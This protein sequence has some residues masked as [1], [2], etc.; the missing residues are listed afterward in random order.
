M[1][2]VAKAIFAGPGRL[3][4]V[5]FLVF[6]LVGVTLAKPKLGPPSIK[7]RTN[8]SNVVIAELDSVSRDHMLTF[9][10]RENLHNEQDESIVIRSDELTSSRL[11][12]GQTYVMAFVKWSVQS[13]PRVVKPRRDGAVIIYLPGAEPA[14]FQ[15]NDEMIELF[16]IDLEESLQSPDE[17]LPV[18]LRGMSEADPQLQ[19][20][21]ATELVTRPRLY[22]QLSRKEKRTVTG[23]I[24]DPAYSPSARDL[25][26]RTPAFTETLMRQN[27]KLDIA[28]EI[29]SS[30]PVNVE[31]GSAM[32][33]LIRTAMK[34]VEDN[35]KSSDAQ[36]SRRWLHSNQPAL[37]ESA[38][39]IIHAAEPDE[40]VGALE[41]ANENT[42]LGKQ[43]R[44]TLAN[45]LQR[46]NRA[47]AEN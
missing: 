17:M 3:C 26:L 24:A 13:H 47:D 45:L 21:F 7:L 36:E 25:M 43:S 39:A 35:A 19:N 6:G 16:L 42:L 2:H 34:I 20:F 33:S 37:I 32:G 44:E 23:Y 38:A 12:T 40:L 46:Y 1:K 30:Y 14:I 10:I 9:T 8:L 22:M 31:F 15:P 29:L 41:E 5:L 28:R 18:I 11:Q 4:L 27:A